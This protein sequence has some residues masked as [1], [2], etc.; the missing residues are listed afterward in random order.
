MSIV[1]TRT[2]NH[3][4]TV[5]MNNPRKLNGWTFEMI[6]GLHAALR[7]AADDPD[8]KAIIVTG[9]DPYYCA[10]VNLGSAIRPSHPRTLYEG[11]RDYNRAV[12][13]AFIDVPKPI[14]AAVNGPAIGAAVTTASLCDAI[15]CSD[16][17]T[18]STPFAKLGV[19]AEGCSS[20]Q[21]QRI[22]GASNAQRMLGPEGW[23]P[24]GADAVEIGLAEA[25]VPHDQL[26]ERA[27]AIAEAWI[28]ED[29]PRTYPAGASKDELSA[30]NTRES[31][32]VA[33]A[34]LQPPFLKGQ[35]EFL[36]AK[37]KRRMAA[38]FWVF[39]RT[40]PLWNWMR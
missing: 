40:H 12:F 19:P 9:A 27:Q 10:G 16:K 25:V 6:E 3:V 28:A 15:V 14:L 4:T 35:Y 38:L 32:A 36:R 17:A 33:D 29:R 5:T 34:F 7:Q 2:T 20:V 21:F 24:T 8:C 31:E 37:K 11:I 30:I 13:Q 26:L 18:F 1:T 23:K 22:M 39:W